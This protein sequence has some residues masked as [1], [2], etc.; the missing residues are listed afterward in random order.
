LTQAATKGELADLYK[1]LVAGLVL[2][3]AKEA[4]TVAPGLTEIRIVVVR[5]TPADA[6]GEIR[7]EPIL[8]ARV[9]RTA[10]NG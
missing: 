10:L 9:A 3:T 7:L 8:A 6:Y 2:T 1:Q 5:N 4:F